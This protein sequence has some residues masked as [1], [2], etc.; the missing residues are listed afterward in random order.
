MK[1]NLILS[2]AILAMTF[3]GVYQAQAIPIT[4][5]LVG[6][7][8]GDG[9]A[10]DLSGNNNHGTLENGATFGTGIVGQAFSL[11]GMD[12]YVDIPF[13]NGSLGFS[14]NGTVGAWVNPKSLDALQHMIFI[15]T[16]E[17]GPWGIQLALVS[18]DRPRTAVVI[19]DV[20]YPQSSDNPIGIDEWHHL[21]GVREGTKL[22]LYIDGKL[23]SEGDIPSGPLRTGSGVSRIGKAQNIHPFDEEYHG[24]IDEVSV[25]DRALSDFEILQLANIPGQSLSVT[26]AST[27]IYI[28]KDDDSDGVFDDTGDVAV[29]VSANNRSQVGEFDTSMNKMQRLVAKFALPEINE[30]LFDLESAKLRFYLDAILGT[31]EGPLSVFHSETDNDLDILASDYENPSYVDTMLD[32]IEPGDSSGQ[33][34]ELDVTDLVLADYAADGLDPLSAFRLEVSEAVFFEDGV[35]NSYRLLM[36]G[37]F[38]NHPELVLAFTAVPE[39]STFT[40]ALLALLGLVLCHRRRRA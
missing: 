10:D 1:R 18:I 19:D 35:K 2:L 17:P 30:D 36:P 28:L 9:T 21:A 25:Y 39:P 13:G 40:L 4:D 26:L 7:W 27:R 20:G 3:A 37:A 31:P 23:D 12:D 38:S 33:Y 11:D 29:D 32:L 15:N 6:Y 14:G 34:Y 22:R 8:P 24:L 5:G 16:I